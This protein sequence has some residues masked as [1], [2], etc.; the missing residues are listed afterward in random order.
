MRSSLGRA[1]VAATLLALSTVAAP[2]QESTGLPGCDAYFGWLDAYRAKCIFPA[3]PKA[4]QESQ[5]KQSEAQRAEYRKE[6]KT[7]AG[8]L[9]DDHCKSLLDTVKSAGGPCKP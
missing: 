2:A 7:A 6:A 8:K 3:L 5:R 9:L 1:A 4:E